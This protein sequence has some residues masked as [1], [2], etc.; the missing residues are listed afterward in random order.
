MDA[1][2]SA[3]ALSNEWAE[4]KSIASWS[5]RGRVRSQ[6]LLGYA[7]A[8]AL[9]M[10]IAAAALAHSSSSDDP[11]GSRFSIDEATQ[12][13]IRLRGSAAASE[14]RNLKS[15]KEVIG[16]AQ[17]ILSQLRNLVTGAA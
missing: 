16:K 14:E 4:A 5:V 10:Q 3:V 8:P 11:G 6:K 13:L 1:L 15:G 17:Q 2:K 7:H 12:E 9:A